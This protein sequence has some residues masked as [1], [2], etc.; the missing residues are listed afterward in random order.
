MGFARIGFRRNA[1]NL[2]GKLKLQHLRSPPEMEV[3]FEYLQAAARCVYG[4]ARTCRHF[5]LIKDIFIKPWF[6]AW[7]NKVVFWA[8]IQGTM[9]ALPAL[10]FT[11]YA[12]Y[13]SQA[14]D[15]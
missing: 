7:L 6:Y 5:A 12:Q 9:T 10:R 14:D 11:T 2:I 3:K 13:K 8:S 15:S 1:D 4:V